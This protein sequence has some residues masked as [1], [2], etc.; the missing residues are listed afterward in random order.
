[1]NSRHHQSHLI[2]CPITE[3]TNI[4]SRIILGWREARVNFIPE[5][6]IILTVSLLWSL[7][8]M[9]INRIFAFF[10]DLHFIPND[11][12]RKEA[13]HKPIVVYA[14][15]ISEIGCVSGLTFDS[16]RFNWPKM[17]AESGRS[18]SNVGD[19]SRIIWK[20]KITLNNTQ[21]FWVI[22]Q[23]KSKAK[24]NKDDIYIYLYDSSGM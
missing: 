15:L 10:S 3:Q 17:R 18:Q 8:F 13:Y 23:K 19:F 16:A 2:F 14:R 4:A 7:L 22:L 24:R 21:V 5:G 6:I 11:F 20:S 12:F 9:L 1:M